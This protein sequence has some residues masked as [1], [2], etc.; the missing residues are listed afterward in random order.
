MNLRDFNPSAPNLYSRKL[1]GVPSV[2]TRTV[3]PRTAERRME[4]LGNIFRDERG[5]RGVPVAR[6]DGHLVILYNIVQ[7]VPV[8][9]VWTE[10]VRRIGTQCQGNVGRDDKIAYSGIQRR[11][12]LF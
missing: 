10:S 11:Q 7:L 4:I 5:H 2:Q 3:P 9:Q 8:A 12:I 6:H 1:A